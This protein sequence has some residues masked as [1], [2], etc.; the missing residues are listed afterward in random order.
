MAKERVDQGIAP[1][2]P[3]NIR[4]E[5]CFKTFTANRLRRTACNYVFYILVEFELKLSST[6]FREYGL[7][8]K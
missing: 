7:F 1:H 2:V 4:M 8:D 5:W 6:E 3:E